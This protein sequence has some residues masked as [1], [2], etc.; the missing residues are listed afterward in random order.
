M[1]CAWVPTPNVRAATDEN[2]MLEYD[3][4]KNRKGWYKVDDVCFWS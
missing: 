4:D 1:Q 2:F 3:N